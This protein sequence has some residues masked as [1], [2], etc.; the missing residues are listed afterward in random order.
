MGGHLV[1]ITSEEEQAKVEQMI[2]PGTMEGYWLGSKRTSPGGNFAWITGEAFEYTKWHGSQPDYY[3]GNEEYLMIYRSSCGWN[4]LDELCDDIFG[5][6]G[7]ICEWDSLDPNV[8]DQLLQNSG[9]QQ[10]DI[11]ISLIWDSYDDL[12]LHVFAP[13]GSEIYYSNPKACGGELDVDANANDERKADP[14]ENIYFSDPISGE[15]WVYVYNYTD[16]TEGRAT[17]Y[18]VRITVGGESQT[19]SGTIANEEDTAEILGFRYSS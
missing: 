14:V 13:D 11:T 7:F 10:G 18:L 12:D 4:D 2:T 6:C 8:M 17:N 5:K 1:T 15:Y 3:L 16:R 19:F 9:A